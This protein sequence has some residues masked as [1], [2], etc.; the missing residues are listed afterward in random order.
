MSMESVYRFLTLVNED[1]DIQTKILQMANGS[2][3]DLI[4]LARI[5]GCEFN[6][7]EFHAV[8]SKTYRKPQ[9]ELSDEDLEMVT[10]GVMSNFAHLP[11]VQTPPSIIAILIGL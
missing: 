4:A 6:K 1:A 10:G 2:I 11:T 9:N 5:E 7:D 3:H 8:A